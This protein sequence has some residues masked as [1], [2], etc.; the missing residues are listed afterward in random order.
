MDSA[1]WDT[2]GGRE[3]YFNKKDK[4][5]SDLDIKKAIIENARK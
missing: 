4:K 2:A 5:F 1:L 3:F